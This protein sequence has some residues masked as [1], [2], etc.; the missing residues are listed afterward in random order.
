M[1]LTKNFYYQGPAMPGATVAPAEYN[2]YKDIRRINAIADVSD[3]LTAGTLCYLTGTTNAADMTPC[4]TEHGQIAAGGFIC[5]V[6]IEEHNAYYATTTD[7]AVYPNKMPNTTC[8]RATYSPAQ[9][10]KIIVIPLEEEMNVWILGSN[11]GSFDTTAFTSYISA[12]NGY[13]KAE[14]QPATA[15]IDLRVQTFVSLAT[16]VDQN[17]AFCRYKGVRPYDSS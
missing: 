7:K 13:I 10:T 11:D 2:V 14:G 9:N 12:A 6:E 17:W 5:V 1:T 3:L 16:T 8:T 4:I 15:A